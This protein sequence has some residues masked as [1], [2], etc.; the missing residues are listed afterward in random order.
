[1]MYHF[2]HSRE[3]A[4]FLKFSG[5]NI[6][7]GEKFVCVYQVEI[8]G[9]CEITGRNGISFYKR[10]TEFNIVFTLGSVSQMPKQQLTHHGNMAF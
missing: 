8:P 4:L 6:Y 5:F 2:H 10:M 3:V 1:M 9:Q 7:Q